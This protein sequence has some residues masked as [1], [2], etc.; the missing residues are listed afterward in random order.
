MRIGELAREAGVSTKAVRYYERLGLVDPAR[1]P[2]GYRSFGENDVRV[3]MEVRALSEIGISPSKA[4][5]FVECLDLGHEHGDERVSSL[6]VY[7]DTITDL[8]R[9]I[10]ALSLRR[11]ALQQ[12]LDRSAERSFKKENPM[13]DYTT[14]PE[15]LPVPEDDGAAHG[16]PGSSMPRLSLPASDGRIIDFSDLGPGRTVVSC[17]RSPDGPAWTCRRDGTRSPVRVAVR[18]RPVTSVTTSSSFATQ[19]QSGCSASPARA[20][21]TRRRSSSGCGCRSA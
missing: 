1:E 9:M 12:R 15:G 8:E 14:L 2:N 7:R 4:G 17:T 18:L 20:L 13:S 6:T 16:L 10:D 21:S 5:P 19:A 11:D 3:V